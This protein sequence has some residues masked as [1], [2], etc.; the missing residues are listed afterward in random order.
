[1]PAA[2]GPDVRAAIM[3]PGR[4][5]AGSRATVIVEMTLGTSWHV[6]SHTPSEKYLI[7]TEVS[8]STSEGNLSSI[9]YPKDVQRSFS[10]SDKPLRVYEGTVRFETDLQ[11]PSGAAGEISIK[12]FLSY[13]ACNAR[14]CFSPARIPLETRISVS[15]GEKMS[16]T[17]PAARPFPETP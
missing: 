4:A 12:G 17:N 3:A 2:E 1:V 15:G 8:L 7:P 13:Q 16:A 14:Q 6:N 9:R 11:L 5:S 10:F